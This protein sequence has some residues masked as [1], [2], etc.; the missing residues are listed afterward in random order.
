MDGYLDLVLDQLGDDVTS[1]AAILLYPQRPSEETV[2]ELEALA[3]ARGVIIGFY[4]EMDWYTT[5]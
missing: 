5:S 2:S 4:N 1:V 3:L